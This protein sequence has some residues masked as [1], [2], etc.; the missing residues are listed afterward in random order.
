MRFN[1]HLYWFL[2]AGTLV[3]LWAVRDQR[4][5]GRVF[6]YDPTYHWLKQASFVE[7]LEIVIF[8]LNRPKEGHKFVKIVFKSFGPKQLEERVLEGEDI[9]TVHVLRDAKCDENIPAFVSE[10]TFP[11]MSGKFQIS[12]HFKAEPPPKIMDLTCYLALTKDAPMN[13]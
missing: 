8:Q 1:K 7:N 5:T 12:R 6:A 3:P 10:S 11:E 13:R 4:L 2:I 9:L